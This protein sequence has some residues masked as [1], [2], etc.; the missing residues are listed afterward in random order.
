MNEIIESFLNFGFQGKRGSSVFE[1]ELFDDFYI[2]IK[3]EDG[4]TDESSISIYIN[5]QRFAPFIHNLFSELSIAELI[6]P[7]KLTNDDSG[8]LCMVSTFIEC[9]NGEWIVWLYGEEIKLNSLLLLLSEAGSIENFY[10][11]IYIEN[12]RLFVWVETIWV[13]LY[14]KSCMA[15]VLPEEIYD[16]INKEQMSPIVKR[17]GLTSLPTLDMLAK[18]LKII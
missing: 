2:K 14:L 9:V 8:C 18:V 7:R 16:D 10:D 5:S 15:I 11:A 17:W 12:N 13:Y 6:Q 1:K 3:C 4:W